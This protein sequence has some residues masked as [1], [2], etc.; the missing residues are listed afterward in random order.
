MRRRKV[1][2]SLQK[3]ST[4]KE[5]DNC[6]IGRRLRKVESEQSDLPFDELL[7]NPFFLPI[8][9]V[10]PSRSF[11]DIKGRV[12]ISS[13]FSKELRKVIIDV[14]LNNREDPYLGTD[15]QSK[16]EF[17]LYDVDLLKINTSRKELEVAVSGN[18]KGLDYLTKTSMIKITSDDRVLDLRYN[19]SLKDMELNV[20]NAEL[21]VFPYVT[22]SEGD[23]ENEDTYQLKIPNS[24]R[25]QSFSLAGLNETPAGMRVEDI[26]KLTS[27]KFL[28]IPNSMW[29]M[30]FRNLRLPDN[31]KYIRVAVP[32][33]FDTENGKYVFY[34]SNRLKG[35]YKYLT[36]DIVQKGYIEQGE[37]DEFANT[38]TFDSYAS[39]PE[40]TMLTENI[41]LIYLKD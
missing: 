4:C 38:I 41:A 18:I 37:Y 17:P 23:Y 9:L 26:Y 27:L 10:V 32:Y 34:I 13:F 3:C 21:I 40:G 16:E 20:P 24:P 30:D 33:H 25:L 19:T 36:S 35:G 39:I 15:K 6:Y 22:Y 11:V 12:D 31:L 1:D 2:G 7:K 28:Y 8:D 5:H 29:N 14:I